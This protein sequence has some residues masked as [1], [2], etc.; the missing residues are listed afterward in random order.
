MNNVMK[1]ILAFAAA[2]VLLWSFAAA[3]EELI[4]EEETEEAAAA[5][6]SADEAVTEKDGWHFN[7]KGF[8]VGENPG[9]EYLLEDEENGVWQ[10]ASRDLSI[11]ITRVREKLKKPKKTREYCVAEVYASESSPLFSISTE[12]T[13][14]RI[15]GYNKLKPADLVKDNPVMLAISDDYYGHRLQTKNAGKAKWPV[16][17]IIRNGTIL[18]DTT[19]TGKKVEFPPLDTLAVYAD[20]S[21]KADPV[22]A[23][24]A[25]EFL[26]EGAAQVFAFGPWLISDGVIN[27]KGVDS[28]DKTYMYNTGRYTDSRAAIGM[29]EPYHYIAIVVKG[30]PKDKYNGVKF[31]WLAEKML[32]LGCVEALNLDGGGTACIYFNG[33]E[34]IRGDKAVRALG[35]MIAFGQ[36]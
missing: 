8:L 16:G 18:G 2:L 4:V 28:G 5:A 12:A 32:E 21:M 11:R 7:A 13:E 36:Q 25:E 24:T 34:I 10:Y 33:K 26:A 22:A 3:D 14:K 30:R 6:E 27:E 31:D 9:E 35:S 1:R 17:I 23:K 29:V 19:R 15:A 20:G